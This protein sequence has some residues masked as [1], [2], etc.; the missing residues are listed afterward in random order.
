MHKLTLVTITCLLLLSH[1]PHVFADSENVSKEIER[2]ETGENVKI[3]YYKDGH[4]EMFVSGSVTMGVNVNIDS[5]DENESVFN[6]VERIETEENCKITYYGDGHKEMFVTG[7]VDMH[8]DVSGT[9]Q[10]EVTTSPPPSEPFPID[11]IFGII[12]HILEALSTYGVGGSL[13]AWMIWN[14]IKR[15]R[16]GRPRDYRGVIW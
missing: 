1:F 3:V 7:S 4:K 9:A 10:I 16:H 14:V 13:L 12:K 2:I 8:F 11:K 5:S 6:K 15:L